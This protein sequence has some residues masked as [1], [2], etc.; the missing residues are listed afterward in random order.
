MGSSNDRDRIALRPVTAL[1]LS[2]WL[3]LTRALVCSQSPLVRLGTQ[4]LYF[5]A[6]RERESAAC[7]VLVLALFLCYTLRVHCGPTAALLCALSV[8]RLGFCDHSLISPI[9]EPVARSPARAFRDYLQLHRTHTHTHTPKHTLTH[10]HVK[11]EQ[12]EQLHRIGYRLCSPVQQSASTLIA[13]IRSAFA[14]RFPL[15]PRFGLRWL[16][17]TAGSNERRQF[18]CVE[19]RHSEHS[20]M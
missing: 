8:R 20:D 16:L 14:A 6:R 1:S 7:C 18:K 13:Q 9:A 4:T 5:Y 19:T 12:R 3:S 11:R 2:L 10:S 15:L 17:I